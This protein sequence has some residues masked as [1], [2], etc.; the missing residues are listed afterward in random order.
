MSLLNFNF[1]MSYT[2]HKISVLIKIDLNDQLEK[3]TTT[4]LRQIHLHFLL[5]FRLVSL[6]H[7]H[8][9]YIFSV[10]YIFI[11]KTIKMLY[12]NQILSF[13]QF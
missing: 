12:N 1:I 2:I 5:S 11:K 7:S 9:C 3:T 8:N 4:K 10:T 13:K 6:R